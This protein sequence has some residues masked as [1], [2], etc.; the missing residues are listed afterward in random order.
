MKTHE[1]QNNR[2]LFGRAVG[3]VRSSASSSNKLND[4]SLIA[5]MALFVL[6]LLN[7]LLLLRGDVILGIHKFSF[8]EGDT[9]FGRDMLSLQGGTL[10]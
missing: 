5:S 8:A 10:D 6:K 4:A 3:A 7:D 9:F 2:L 1:H